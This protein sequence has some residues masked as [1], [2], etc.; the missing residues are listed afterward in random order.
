[1]PQ[2][3][4]TIFSQRGRGDLCTSLDR[5]F[6]VAMFPPPRFCARARKLAHSAPRPRRSQSVSAAKA[7]RIASA[8]AS[9]P[10]QARH[11]FAR[12]SLRP[13]S[14]VSAVQ[15]RHLSISCTRHGRSFA[16]FRSASVARAPRLS[17]RHACARRR[18][19]FVAKQGSS[20][21]LFRNTSRI[22][23]VRNIRRMPWI[24]KP[25]LNSV[26]GSGVN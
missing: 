24:S 10:R 2:R 14:A 16:S 25:S 4:A 13:G 3:P 26:A 9:V 22:R 12:S 15:R 1:M 19:P 6:D 7:S 18:Q 21:H 11:A 23:A 8:C 5:R 20:R 17:T